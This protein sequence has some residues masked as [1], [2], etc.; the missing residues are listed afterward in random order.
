MAAAAPPADAGPAPR[1]VLGDE[2]QAF[3]T[4]LRVERRLAARQTAGP[5]RPVNLDPGYLESG[6]LILASMKNFS[7]RVYLS[8][9]VYAEV[10]LMFR[11]GRWRALD[12]SGPAGGLG[13]ARH[14]A[15]ARVEVE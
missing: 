6:K 13:G 8:A 4:H 7:H 2:L 12:R 5:P 9:G 15:D 11:H 10:T 14:H 1:P 3:L